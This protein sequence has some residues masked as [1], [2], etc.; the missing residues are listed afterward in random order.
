MSLTY[1]GQIF[2]LGVKQGLSAIHEGRRYIG[3]VGRG[4][5][6]VVRI[7][8]FSSLASGFLSD[9]LRS[10]SKD[11]SGV[12]TEL[13]DGNPAEHVARIRQL[14]L[15]VVF[16]TGTSAWSECETAHLWSERVFAVLPEEQ[17]LA[18]KE[19]LHWADLAGEH[20][21]VSDV[22]PGPQIHE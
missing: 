15:D 22:A 6:G 16:I 18:R 11:H 17:A 7:G 4:E 12:R 13:I 2:L 9:L 20:F 5:E 3:S 10:Y 14:R 19:I 21:I 1:A 8:I